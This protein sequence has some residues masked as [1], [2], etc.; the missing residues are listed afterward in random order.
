M[1]HR[2]AFGG[3]NALQTLLDRTSSIV[4]TKRARA[5]AFVAPSGETIS[6]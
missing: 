6:S 1:S 4:A 3:S 2:A 5:G